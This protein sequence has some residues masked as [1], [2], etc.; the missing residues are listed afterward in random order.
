MELLGKAVSL[1]ASVV[2]IVITKPP[3][4]VSVL[5]DSRGE[6]PKYRLFDSHTRPE[7]GLNS[8]YLCTGDDLRECA[9]NLQLCFPRI[10]G[11]VE[12]LAVEL[13]YHSFEAHFFYVAS[14]PLPPPSEET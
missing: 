12:E 1:P 10:S 6:K 13:S 4:T 3:M 2:G 11:Q 14:P 8:A 5:V 9:K 7:F